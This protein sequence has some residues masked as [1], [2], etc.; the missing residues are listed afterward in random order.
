LLSGITQSLAGRVALLSLLPFSLIEL[1]NAEQAPSSLE[2]LLFQGSYPPVYDRNL[3]PVFWY[4]NYIRTYIERD[5]RQLINVRDLTTF[6]RF[7]YMCAARTG[8]LVNLSSLANDC[9]IDHTTAK[10]WM[11]VLEVSYLIY[12]LP[13]YFNNF[14]KRII[15]S[16]KLYF[17][18]TGLVCRLLGLQTAK[19][20]STHPYRGPL[21]ETWVVSEMLKASFNQSLSPNL[22]FWRDR[23]GHEIDLLI[24]QAGQLIPIEVKSGQTLASDFFKGIMQWRGLAGDKT[25][26]AYLIYGGN[27]KQTRQGIHAIP[28]DAVASLQSIVNRV[29]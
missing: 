25:K 20:L 8:Q 2:T 11:S 9:G 1:Q 6:R 21:F 23:S 15:K 16:S 12:L 13:P 22:Y 26:Q 18:D 19:Q 27:Q 14:N 24:E 3:D 29:D 5:V 10:A 4:E 17:L 7:V 28:W